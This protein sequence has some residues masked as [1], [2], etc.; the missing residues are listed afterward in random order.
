MKLPDY[1]LEPD[2]EAYFG[3][4]DMQPMVDENGMPIDPQASDD[5]LRP[6]PDR[7]PPPQEEDR[8]GL[9][10]QW[11]DNALNRPGPSNRPNP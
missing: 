2:A 11:I 7:A 3:N 9:D 6:Q 10:Q 1:Q 5:Y 4:N 8:G